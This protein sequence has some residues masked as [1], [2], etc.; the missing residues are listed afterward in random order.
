ML[1]LALLISVG[2]IPAGRTGTR[3]F[4][5]ACPRGLEPLLAHEL[6]STVV[7]GQRVEE[8]RAGVWFDGERSVGM[9]AVLW[10]RTANRVMEL[11]A[12]ARAEPTRNEPEAW[13]TKERLYDFGRSIDWPSLLTPANCGVG[14]IE[15]CTFAC[16]ATVGTV[17]RSLCNSHFTALELKNALVDTMREAHDGLRPTVDTVEPRLPLHV[18]VHTDSC[19][20]FRTLS[21]YG[22]LHRRGYR[23]AMHVAVLRENL[24][25][26]MVL[27]AAEEARAISGQT[28]QAFWASAVLCDPLCGS[29]TLAAEAALIASRTAPGLLRWGALGRRL[30]AAEPGSASLGPAGPPPLCF[31]PDYDAREWADE[32]AAAE[33]ET[34]PLKMRVM[35]NDQ[36]A[37]ALSLAR[38]A[39]ERLG[40]DHAV[41]Y[42]CAEID[43]YVPPI[44]PT[45]VL[46]N[47]PWG[48]RIGGSEPGRRGG[49]REGGRGGRG[50]A[51]DDDDARYSSGEDEASYDDD[52]APF[53]GS[54]D[55][56]VAEGDAVEAWSSLG[57][58]AKTNAGA[59]GLT[60]WTLCGSADLTQH[61]RMKATRKVPITAGGVDLRWIRYD[62]LPPKRE[63]LGEDGKRAFDVAPQPERVKAE[64][65]APPPRSRSTRTRR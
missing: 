32:V 7:G 3:S 55:A 4:F 60:L 54:D 9:R 34:R 57:R 11:L 47:P 8:G 24:A 53:E 18:H 63:W 28:E 17:D 16:D 33:A 15:D 13:F 37:A 61:L 45:L 48:R 22:S 52:E 59:D 1:H 44:A 51:Y 20:L 12:S 65:A 2:M 25:A 56:P 14:S 35:L 46:T 42:S 36:N 6:R 21:P 49:E 29:G 39:F 50:G 26:G 19:W 40:F 58:F 23:Q 30:T 31:W 10:S 5:A 38:Q 43:S 41:S 27:Q 62:V 64:K